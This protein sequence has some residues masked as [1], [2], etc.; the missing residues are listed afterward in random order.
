MPSDRH[1]ATYDDS[2]TTYI[3]AIRLKARPFS[4]HS[5][6]ITPSD[7]RPLARCCLLHQ[8][9]AAAALQIMTCCEKSSFAQ[10]QAIA[11]CICLV[12]HICWI[13]CR[14]YNHPCTGRGCYIY[15]SKSWKLLA[16]SS[17]HI[18][19]C[20][21]ERGRGCQENAHVIRYNAALA[22]GI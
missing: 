19:S 20:C 16:A 2:H 1:Y 22:C 21:F 15:P 3:T 13:Q 9:S 17:F 5:E 7:P 12:V 11:Q 8:C 14:T 6:S 10:S 4:E 18:I